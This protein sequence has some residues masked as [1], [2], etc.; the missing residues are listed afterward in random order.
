MRLQLAA[1]VVTHKAVL[2]EVEMARVV[3]VEEAVVATQAEMVVGLQEAAEVITVDS[4]ASQL[5]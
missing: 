2:A 1:L 3:M 5:Q 4:T